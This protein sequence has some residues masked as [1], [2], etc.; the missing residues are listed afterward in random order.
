MTFTCFVGVV[1]SGVKVKGHP[2]FSTFFEENIRFH[3]YYQII[4][5]NIQNKS[6]RIIAE[7]LWSSSVMLVNGDFFFKLSISLQWVDLCKCGLVARIKVPLHQKLSRSLTFFFLLLQSLYHGLPIRRKRKKVWC[8]LLQ[9][10][11]NVSFPTMSE[12]AET[13][14]NFSFK[15]GC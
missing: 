3:G 8:E 12:H 11:K 15:G 2:T 5:R 7:A 4:M 10:I 14:R 1:R 9:N 13:L 6:L